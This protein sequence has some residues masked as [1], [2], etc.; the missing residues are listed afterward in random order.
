MDSVEK[1]KNTI[2][3]GRKRS[4]ENIF[5]NYSRLGI[6]SVSTERAWI[7]E[8]IVLIYK[9]RLQFYFSL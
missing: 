5:T 7:S 6:L 1:I 9:L 2:C 3:L 8:A 4:L